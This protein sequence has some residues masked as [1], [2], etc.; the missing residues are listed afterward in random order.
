MYGDIYGRYSVPYTANQ[1]W[2]LLP[3][4]KKDSANL[5]SFA[6]NYD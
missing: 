4:E 2:N 1:V 3:R 6:K 5:D